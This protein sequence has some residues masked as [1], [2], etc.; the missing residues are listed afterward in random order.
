MS[1]F[2]LFYIS[3]LFFFVH[4]NNNPKKGT[5]ERYD[6]IINPFIVFSF[7]FS[8]TIGIT[9]L[10][11]MYIT[12]LFVFKRKIYTYVI[13]IEIKTDQEEKEGK[14]Q[15]EQ[16]CIFCRRHFLLTRVCYPQK[17]K[18]SCCCSHVFSLLFFFF[19]DVCFVLLFVCIFL[20]CVHNQI[21]KTIIPT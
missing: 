11:T 10:H 15:R 9:Q 18:V 5:T 14:N 21:H 19:F 20:L 4:W 12:Y 7:I 6:E 8:S 1:E 2:I 13:L 3:V 17:N 16:Q